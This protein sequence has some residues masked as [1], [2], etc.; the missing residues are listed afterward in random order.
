M[1]LTST[2]VFRGRESCALGGWGGAL[3][4][5]WKKN[6]R[7]LW[8]NTSGEIQRETWGEDG[9]GGLLRGRWAQLFIVLNLAVQLRFYFWRLCCSALDELCSRISE[10]DRISEFIRLEESDEKITFYIR[11]K[12][13]SASASWPAASCSQVLHPSRLSA[14]LTR[15]FS[16][17]G[18]RTD[19][20]LLKL[21]LTVTSQNTSVANY[22]AFIM[23]W[24]L[25]HECTQW[26]VKMKKWCNFSVTS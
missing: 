14:D 3:C 21:K 9:A 23:I 11:Q 25:W 15:T 17:T 18:G 24:W 22:P 7:I 1:L 26:M 5:C 20:S 2:N 12:D 13:F 10:L 19:H 8:G 16:W 4:C 6:Y